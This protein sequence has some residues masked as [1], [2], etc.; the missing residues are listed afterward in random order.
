M[1]KLQKSIKQSLNDLT[2]AYSA[3]RCPD[4]KISIAKNISV[5]DFSLEENDMKIIDSFTRP[6]VPING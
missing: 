4:S 3:R 6:D 5:F 2:L 1:S